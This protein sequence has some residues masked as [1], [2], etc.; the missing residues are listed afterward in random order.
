MKK[1]RLAESMRDGFIYYS[2]D[3]MR[4]SIKEYNHVTESILNKTF[5]YFLKNKLTAEANA[6]TYYYDNGKK[7]ML[8][9]GYCGYSVNV[10]DDA[11]GMI[12]NLCH[13]VFCKAEWIARS[14]KGGYTEVCKARIGAKNYNNIIN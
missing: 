2:R 8:S 14:I 11:E 9:D 3:R 1:V 5:S 12:D 13:H 7:E 6:K 10:R 4:S